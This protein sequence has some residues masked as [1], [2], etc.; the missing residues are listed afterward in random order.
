MEPVI[1]NSESFAVMG[2]QVRINPMQADYHGIWTN[3]FE[4]RQGEIRP[5]VCEDVG[6]GLYFPTE[7]QYLV[8]F[9]AG[10][11]VAGVDTTPEGL[12]LREVPARLE[13]VFECSLHE[14]GP[15][16]HAIFSKWLPTSGYEHDAPHPCYERF[17]PGCHEGTAPVTVHVAV[18]KR[19]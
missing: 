18:S 12:V 4:P 15:T 11:P 10:L 14:L 6:Y 2:V 1:R 3:Q 7:D 16:W 5:H 8:D 13:A 9:V 17:P 19:A